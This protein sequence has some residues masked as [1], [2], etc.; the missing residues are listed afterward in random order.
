VGQPDHRFVIHFLAE[1]SQNLYFV[2][3]VLTYLLW[4]AIRK[5]R[6]TR[7]QLIQFVLAL[8]VYFSALAAS[9]GLAVLNPHNP[10][11]WLGTYAAGLWL[12]V[13][14]GYTFL[15]VP[16]GARLATA[17]VATGSH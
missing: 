13:A 15:K 17:R 9:Y 7:T 16:E 3:A 5:L 11:W 10:I 4:G 6:E 8:G 1:L 12:P 14:W 2:G